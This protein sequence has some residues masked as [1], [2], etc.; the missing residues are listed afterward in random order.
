MESVKC[1]V[2]ERTE[3]ALVWC[4]RPPWWLLTDGAIERQAI[5][6]GQV[7]SSD[8]KCFS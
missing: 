7:G 1:M 5:G 4:L 2:L 8:K 3:S 6:R